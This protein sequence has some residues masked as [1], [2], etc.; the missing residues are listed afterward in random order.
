MDLRDLVAGVAAGLTQDA[1]LHPI[2]TLRARLAMSAAHHDHRGPIASL[3]AE[4]KSAGLAGAYRGY[5]VCLAASGPCNALYFGV[6]SAASRELGGGDSAATDAAAGFVAEACAG[7][8]WTPTEVVKQ[9]LQVAPLDLR[10]IDAVQSACRTLGALGLMRGY[11]AGLAV[12]GPFSATYF[13]T[14]E[15]LMRRLFGGR[16][17]S[18]A[19]ENLAAG[20]CAGGAGAMISQPLDCA[21][22]RIQVGA[23]D[24]SA[25]L[26]GTVAAVW[27]EEGARALWRGAAA[28]AAWLAPG[29]GITITV[30]ERVSHA[31][32]AGNGA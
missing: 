20:I 22:T 19:R 10:A 8:L 14:Y 31:L 26:L 27:R 21:K 16:D 23:V 3:A 17:G 2:D 15:L 24:A 25:T 12:W 28:R 9:R 18:Q 1:L 4:A 6:Y 29:C 30:F 32:R 13:M 11:F 7:L 5:A